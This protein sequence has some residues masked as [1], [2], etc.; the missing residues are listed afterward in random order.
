MNNIWLLHIRPL[1]GW[2]GDQTIIID[3]NTKSP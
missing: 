3:I 2:A 1:I